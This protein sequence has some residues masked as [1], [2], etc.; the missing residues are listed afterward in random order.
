M[1]TG[2]RYY[3]VGGL[4]LFAVAMVAGCG[5]SSSGSGAAFIPPPDSHIDVPLLDRLGRPI[6]AGSSEPYSPRKTCGF[7]HDID[8]MANGYHFQQGRTD[9]NGAIIVKEDYNNDGR[10]FLRSAG[11]YGKW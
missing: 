7:C 8:K 10:K 1:N 11:M 5:G 9:K 2:K 4:L 3:L 6:T